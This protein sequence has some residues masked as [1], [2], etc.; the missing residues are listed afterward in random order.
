MKITSG[1]YEI[2]YSG[3]AIGVEDND[4]EFNFPE[5]HAGLKIIFNF[6]TDNSIKDSKIEFDLPEPKTLKLNLINTN[7]SLGTGNTKLLEIG[8]IENKKLYLNYRIFAITDISNT[9][10]YTFYLGKEGSNGQ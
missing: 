5:H 1:E 7:S 3:T 10:H 9:I 8:F 4:I 2:L 6:K